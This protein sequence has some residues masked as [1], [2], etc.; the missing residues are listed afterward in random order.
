MG[1]H[2]VIDLTNF[3]TVKLYKEAIMDSNFKTDNKEIN[4]STINPVSS[5]IEMVS[6]KI[7]FINFI[8]DVLLLRFIAFL[9]V[10][11]IFSYSLVRYLNENQG[12]AWLLGMLMVFAYYFIFESLTGRTLGKLITSTKV[13]MADGSKPDTMAILKRS[14]VRLV[15]FEPLS[16][17]KSTWWHDRWTGTRV[18]KS[19]G[20]E[21]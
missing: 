4:N 10:Q 7:R 13:V 12:A 5:E 6:T 17:N 3:M 16:G 14:L 15:P 9:L 11:S 20:Q 1:N 2:I 21:F 8:I 18:I 19:W